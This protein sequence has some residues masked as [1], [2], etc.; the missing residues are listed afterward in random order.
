M[1]RGGSAEVLRRFRRQYI[2]FEMDLSVDFYGYLPSE[3]AA[4]F[5]IVYFGTATIACIIQI[6]FGNY[7]HYWMITLALA[8][9]GE[10]IGWGGRL[11]AHFA[12]HEWMAFMIQICSLIISPVFISAADYVLFCKIVEKTGP[13]LFHVR[14]R[15]FWIGFIV[16]DIISLSIQTV[17]GVLVSCAQSLAQLDHG[18]HVMRAGII[19][20]FSNTVLFVALLSLTIF[21]LRKKGMQPLSVAG[22]PVMLAI[23]VSTVMIF[24]RNAYR[25]AELSGGWNGHLMRTEWYLIAWDMVPVAVAV[26]AFV[27]FSPSFFFS[28]G[29]SDAEAKRWRMP[30]WI[31]LC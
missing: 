18:S 29:T 28:D 31:P 7:K 30:D 19:F 1:S 5:G 13:Q 3:P 8:A 11:W 20:Q 25:I 6:I 12:P 14:P 17:G 10:A 26:G 21:R 24:V 2:A 16:L 15:F 22:W 27:V 23:W 9:V 4:L